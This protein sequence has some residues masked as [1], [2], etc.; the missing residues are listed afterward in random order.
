MAIRRILTVNNPADLAVLK[1]VC[2]PVEAVTDD[3]RALMDDM[4]E[5]MYDAPGIGLAAVQVGD[6]RRIV[7]MDLGD[8]GEDGEAPESEDARK[9]NPASSSIR[10]SCGPRKRPRP[11]RKAA[12]R[13]PSISTR[14]SARRGSGCAI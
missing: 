10:R 14:S 6:T 4:L 7:V 1:T 13:S 5:T 9:P 12:C 8:G 3:V 2:T 11:T